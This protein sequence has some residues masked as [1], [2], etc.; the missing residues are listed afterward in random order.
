MNRTSELTDGT[1]VSRT[2]AMLTEEIAQVAVR[3]VFYND[4]KWSVLC[5]AAQQVENIRVFANH[6]HHLHFRNQIH[7]FRIRVTL[8]NLL[9]LSTNCNLK[10]KSNLPL[11]ILTATVVVACGVMMPLA[12]AWTT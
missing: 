6:L 4:V 3:C 12:W 11:S 9:I 5:T 10:I 8:C 2:G 7:Q 1:F